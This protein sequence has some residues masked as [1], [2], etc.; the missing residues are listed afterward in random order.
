MIDPIRLEVFKHLFAAIPE[1]MGVILQKASFSPNIKER[2]DFSCALFDAS[3]RMIAQAAHI[4]VHLGAMPLSVQAAI[5]RFQGPD[6]Q[7]P[8]QTGD[9]IVLNDPFQG[10]SH[11]PDITLVTP[12]FVA[13]EIDGR[14]TQ[15]LQGF[16]ANRAHHADVG[17]I[18]PGSM[19]IG[20]EIYQ[21]GLIIPPI[22][23]VE[24]GRI[25]RSVWDLVLAN[26]RTPQERAGD[27]H[28]QLAANQRGA[29][30]FAG[31]LTRY[32]VDQ[33]AGYSAVLLEYTERLTR[34]LLQAIPDGGYT[35][36]DY[37]DDDGV[38]DAPVP[39]TVTVEIRGDRARVDFSGS[40]PEQA[41]SVNAVRA[42]TLSAVNYVFRLLLGQDVPNNS[43]ALAPIEVIT[44]AGSIVNA[45]HPA[46]VAGGNVETSQRITDVLLGALAQA[47]PDRIPA[48]SQGT[49]NNLTL[50]GLDR[51]SENPRPFTYYETLGGGLGGGPLRPG[52]SA[53]HVHMSN[54]LNTPIEAL[55]YAYPIQVDRYEIR[56]GS[57][58]AGLHPG[59]EGLRRDVR[60]LSVAEANLIGE[61]RR[62]QPYGLQ[63]GEPGAY[64]ENVLIRDGLE[65]PLPA[66]GKIDL[67]P[68]DILSIRT[69]GGGGWGQP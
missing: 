22:K 6:S 57:G 55:E 47:L 39:I 25:N 50:G 16:T 56:S 38:S 49:M 64:G 28:A 29:D 27:L 5:D 40:A 60:V 10:G 48:A 14:P 1:E 41:G 9:V 44:P 32:G 67:Q 17:G 24:G 61:R 37:L 8:L 42:I 4:P 58:G 52:V 2:R 3:A 69:P 20:R 21:E 53:R 33:I 36:T 30:R 43:G 45:R 51:R 66:K 19:A 46:P 63:G 15:S 7:S 62:F 54:T 31:L 26:V 18:A 34:N 35:Y 59:G 12:V 65:I 11:L 23:V 68:G 13:Q